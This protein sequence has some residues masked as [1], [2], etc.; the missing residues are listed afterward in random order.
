M[1]IHD[2]VEPHRD[3]LG[4]FGVSLPLLACQHGERLKWNDEVTGGQANISLPAP[5]GLRSPGV[6]APSSVT[7]APA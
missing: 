7:W 1:V 2:R 5:F 4:S 3:L 6:A